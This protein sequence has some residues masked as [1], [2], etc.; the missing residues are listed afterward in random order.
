L[1]YE[2]AYDGLRAG[3]V[4]AVVALH[5]ATVTFRGGWL[6]V[7]V[8]FVLSG[9]LIS[10]NLLDELKQ[11]GKI[12]CLRFYLRRCL[13]LMPALYCLLA[14]EVVRVLLVHPTDGLRPIL[15]SAAY[16]MNWNSAFGWVNADTLGHTWSLAA[17]EQFYIL[18]PLA[19]AFIFRRRPR[20][21]LAVAIA[22]VV[23]WRIYLVMAGAPWVRTFFAFDTH[24]DGI[25]IGC[26]LASVPISAKIKRWAKSTVIGPVAFLAG[27]LFTLSHTSVFAQTIAV[28]I[29]ALS[30][31]WLIIAATEPGWMNSILTWRPV[32]YTGKISYG[33]YLWHFPIIHLL[34]DTYS[35]WVSVLGI[36]ISFA[37][38]AASYHYV[39]RPFLSMKSKLAIIEQHRSELARSKRL[40]LNTQLHSK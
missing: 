10:H 28:T 3:A 36:P 20:L 11:S 16:L 29:A 37:I 27:S 22:I 25:L 12:D 34:H 15:L 14:A 9:F 39:E 32:V 38:A 21:W 1:R 30:A 23:S 8:F 24:S 31:A 6:G 4:V 13:R 33:W 5:V 17:E 2:P 19:L 18:W 7:D 26:S 40:N 35:A